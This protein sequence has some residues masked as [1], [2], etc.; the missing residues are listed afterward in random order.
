MGAKRAIYFGP[1][2]RPNRGFFYGPSYESIWTND[3]HY[4]ACCGHEKNYFQFDGDG[5]VVGR[6]QTLLMRSWRLELEQQ[7]HERHICARLASP[8]ASK[9]QT[10]E[11]LCLLSPPPTAAP[12]L[13]NCSPEL[14]P[15]S[16]RPA[17]A[18]RFT[19][20][21]AKTPL[22]PK[23]FSR[24]LWNPTHT[25]IIYM[26]TAKRGA[27]RPPPAQAPPTALPHIASPAISPQKAQQQLKEQQQQ[28]QLMQKQQ[29]QQF[30]KEQQRFLQPGPVERH[31]MASSGSVELTRNGEVRKDYVAEV[32]MGGRGIVQHGA[33]DC[34]PASPKSLFLFFA[35][36]VGLL[37][38]LANLTVSAQVKALMESLEQQ[39]LL[40]MLS[41][42]AARSV[43][44]LLICRA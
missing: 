24:E 38:R 31:S 43:F 5:D 2:D 16:F 21:P 28:Q 42:S 15:P 39:R 36:R 13:P 34:F 14:C 19:L 41:K 9:Q 1:P 27:V 32:R 40:E 12:I 17:G 6:P 30:L 20:S 25:R 22:A 29:Q 44:V 26:K 23:E 8:S 11:S 35:L 4:K 10:S 18:K 3:F 33:A 7:A 37:G